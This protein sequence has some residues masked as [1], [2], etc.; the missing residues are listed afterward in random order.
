[1]LAVSWTISDGAGALKRTMLAAIAE[2]QPKDVSVVAIDIRPDLQ[3]AG[4][5]GEGRLIGHVNGNGALE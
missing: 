2:H 3:F 4:I 5:V 1:M